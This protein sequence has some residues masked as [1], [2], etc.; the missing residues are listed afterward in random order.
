[1]IDKIVSGWCRQVVFG[2]GSVACSAGG[3]AVAVTFLTEHGDVPLMTA[4]PTMTVVETIKGSRK[5]E[6]CSGRGYCDYGSGTCD[7][8][9]GYGS[10]DGAGNVGARGDCGA[11]NAFPPH[12]EV[13]KG[14]GV[15][16]D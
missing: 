6:E 5:D 13:T 3:K 10:S 2:S 14:G 15:S 7:C 12:L 8:L 16:V 11:L 4:S 1:M 9:E